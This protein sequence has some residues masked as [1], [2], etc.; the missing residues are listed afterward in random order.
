VNEISCPRCGSE[1]VRAQGFYIA[2]LY[3][4]RYRFVCKICNR[5]FIIGRHLNKITLQ[6]EKEIIRLSNKINPHASKYD[7][8]K[9]KK[10]SIRE[11]AKIM[12]ISNTTI[13][14]VLKDK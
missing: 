10:Y 14:E 8:R 2:K 4:K 5:S 6:Q 9:H 1:K 7:N 12:R 3:K 13:V 11:I